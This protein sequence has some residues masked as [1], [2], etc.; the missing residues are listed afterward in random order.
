[1]LDGMVA[2]EAG[3]ASPVGELYN[4]VP[5]RVSDVATLIGAGFAAGGNVILGFSA[6]LVALFTAYVRAVGKAAGAPQQFCG[7][8]AKQQR[9]FLVSFVGLYCALLPAT[10]QPPWGLMTAS[11]SIIVITGLLTA[12][13]RLLR[14]ARALRS[15]AS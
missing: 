7:P 12:V 1:M 5:D 4:E 15:A 2:I 9:M 14:T 13:R 10:W 11:L 6:S 8:M 3:Q